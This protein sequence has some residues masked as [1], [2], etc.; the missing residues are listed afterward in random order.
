MM[1][2]VLYAM[3]LIIIYGIYI[4]FKKLDKKYEKVETLEH[5]VKAQ[6]YVYRTLLEKYKMVSTPTDTKAVLAFFEDEVNAESFDSRQ[7]MLDIAK[8]VIW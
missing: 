2:Y 6:N 5:D 4:I 8:R 7:E 1:D 3:L